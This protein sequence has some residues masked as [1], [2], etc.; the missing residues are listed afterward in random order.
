MRNHADIYFI[1]AEKLLIYTVLLLRS[2]KLSI[3]FYGNLVKNDRI[4]LYFL[5]DKISCTKKVLLYR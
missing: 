2:F 1:K 3:A 5:N 4:A